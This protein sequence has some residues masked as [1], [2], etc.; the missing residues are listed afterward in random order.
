M[1]LLIVNVGITHN[2]I[3]T[4]KWSYIT[5]T[6]PHQLNQSNKNTCASIVCSSCELAFYKNE[7]LKSAYLLYDIAMPTVEKDSLFKALQSGRY[8]LLHIF[9]H[10]TLEVSLHNQT[11]DYLS[12]H[13]ITCLT[14]FSFS[15]IILDLARA[16]PAQESN[17]FGL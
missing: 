9:L 14:V 4:I 13:L 2:S 16:K 8:L 7:F 10:S 15:E 17:W 12:N 6:K 3:L 1:N 5:V 11:I